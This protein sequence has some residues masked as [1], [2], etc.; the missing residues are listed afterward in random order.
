MFTKCAFVKIF[1]INQHDAQKA[2]KHIDFSRCRYIIKIKRIRE[3]FVYRRAKMKKT[4]RFNILFTA[5]LVCLIGAALI[6]TVSADDTQPTVL[7]EVTQADGSIAK[8]TEPTNFVGLTTAYPGLKAVKL[9]SDIELSGSSK[10]NYIESDLDFDLNGY[11][12]KTNGAYIRPDG[13]AQVTVRNGKINHTS[14][15]FA[16]INSKNAKLTISNCEIS[17]TS[18]FVHQ[19]NGDVVIE[20]S[21]VTSSTSN[22]S[23]L[24]Q[25]SFAGASSNLTVD[26]VTF[27]N[28]K[29]C[30]VNIARNDSSTLKNV[31][32]KN[33]TFS[34]TQSVITFQDDASASNNKLSCVTSIK[35]SGDTKLSF[36]TFV[37]KD[38]LLPA[39]FNFST[40]VK[41]SSVPV[42]NVGDTALAEID[43]IDGATEFGDNTDSD[44]ATYPK[45]TLKRD[46][47]YVLTKTDGD[48]VNVSETKYFH[49]LLSDYGDIKAIKLYA[50]LEVVKIGGTNANN[51]ITKDLDIDLNGRTITANGGYLRPNG[52]S[53][54]V[55]VHG[56]NVSHL[57]SSFVFIDSAGAEFIIDGCDMTVIHNFAQLRA[58]SIKISNSTISSSV[59]NSTSFAAISY[60][61]SV[62]DLTFDGV[63]FKGANIPLVSVGRD[64]DTVSKSITIKDT[65]FETSKWLVNFIDQASA[66]SSATVSF[67]ILG[68]T[69]LSCAKLVNTQAS[70]PETTSFT[71]GEGVLLSG[72]H[73]IT[74][75]KVLFSGGANG[76]L[77]NDDEVYKVIVANT[78]PK[79]TIT[80]SD[81]NV[82]NVYKVTTLQELFKLADSG[83]VIKLF[84]DVDLS[85]EIASSDTS[86]KNV[87]INLN[88]YT[89]TNSGARFRTYGESTITF[90]GGKVVDSAEKQF[91]F[92]G[93]ADTDKNIK[94]LFR[95]CE[96]LADTSFIQLRNGSL[97]FEDCVINT[98]NAS[99]LV[100]LSYAG[101]DA[102]ITFDG[103]TVNA[104]NAIPVSIMRNDSEAVRKVKFVDTVVNANGS[105][106][107]FEDSGMNEKTVTEIEILG[108]SQ[109]K[110]KYIENETNTYE[111]TTLKI[112]LGVKFSNP[113]A[114]TLGSIVFGE[115]AEGIAKVDDSDYPYA[116]VEKIPLGVKPQFALTLYTDF[117]LNLCFD[118]SELSK[119][120]S[121]KLGDTALEYTQNS[122]RI[123]YAIKGISPLTVDEKQKI[124][125]TYYNYGFATT[126]T[127]EYSVMDY[128]NALLKSDYSDESK[129]LVCRAVD[130]VAAVCAYAG[131][132]VPSGVGEFIDSD[133]YVNIGNS[134]W[135][136]TV[137]QSATNVGE[138]YTVINSANIVI[139]TDVRFR[140][141]L[142]DNIGSGVL[143]VRSRTASETYTVEN[144]LINGQPY[145][146]FDMRAFEYYNGIVEITY[147][148]I[149]GS[150]D[151]KTYANSDAVKLSTNEKVEKLVVA[152]YNYFREANEYARVSDKDFKSIATVVVKGDKSGTVTYI[153]DD[154]DAPTGEYTAAM[155]RDYDNLKI[156]YGLIGEKYATLE[157]VYN[158]Q[159]GKYEYV[160]DENG[161]YVYTVN[162]SAAKLWREL[163]AEFSD[164]I[165]YT[166][167][168][169]THDFPGY[170]DEGG[171]VQYVDTSG[172]IKTVTL[173]AGS[174]S[175]ELY[176]T[177]QVFNELFGEDALTIVEAGVPAQE[178]DIVI[179]G[180]LYRGYYAYY[181]ELLMKLYEEGLLVG[182]RG[183]GTGPDKQY[184]ITPDALADLNVRFD[185][186]AYTLRHT[187]TVESWKQYIDY[188]TESGGWALLMLHRIYADDR[189]DVDHVIHT[190]VSATREL[191]EYT[192]RDDVWVA[193]LT[194]ATKYYSEWATSTVSTKILDG[195]IVLTV[196][197]TENNEVYDEALTVKVTV[198][199]A[200]EACIVNGEEIK[201]LTAENG[202]SYVLV[203]VVPDSGDVQIARK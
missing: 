102:S 81:G 117:T 121:V 100:S 151:F 15:Y 79:Y 67:N 145:F 104:G 49:E 132:D 72:S 161:K 199:S 23:G 141:Y 140:F 157:T 118:E 97:T 110:C 192:E 94:I 5:L 193:N 34:T 76:F 142:N 128:I 188:A 154:G 201:V 37:K 21:T 38:G 149:S 64:A 138:L 158:E 53:V 83:S 95:D 202:I 162:E 181:A 24:I 137:P 111:N 39:T 175:A 65:V 29:M 116:V 168:T 4:K 62:S 2:G 122:G 27:N 150:Y 134:E 82:V 70:L 78:D 127:I 167:H 159:T 14:S 163:V 129:Q 32:I 56:G 10:S 136:N 179:D 26:G 85:A 169:F 36:K 52:T 22:D 63:T 54:T 80:K 166:S 177:I 55:K 86:N 135:V 146:D 191:F 155:L 69:K 139:N 180:V 126:A 77:E 125:I 190:K 108:S 131:I 164:R 153:F 44:S 144:S 13:S 178:G 185:M 160:F 93:G 61:G 200:W 147:G 89:F 195:V 43:F 187:Q 124:S 123:S 19:R 47:F 186:H 156:T 113:P 87:G 194:E 99:I 66:A 196:T 120:I 92:T 101:T 50:D 115:G 16:F 148:D 98:Q 75:G 25:M 42:A 172:N 182:A 88:G 3:L 46:V 68:E 203:D 33:T 189:T 197:D 28:A 18:N 45:I 90:W 91:L 60:I 57:T 103:C 17:A 174:A 9:H 6:F 11:T 107:K 106:L 184:I 198:P 105:L 133:G 171:T 41:C 40:G 48:T 51:Y 59:T 35:F 30:L 176:A 74:V 170:D 20:N 31:E 7:Y 12:V 73:N 143:T 1:K 96:I 173:P 183:A 58:G 71:F 119:I 84:A 109:I 165:E 152:M 114:L 130:Y 112:A 8:V